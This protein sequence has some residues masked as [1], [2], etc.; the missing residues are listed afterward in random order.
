M[1]EILTTMTIAVPHA[2]FL[3]VETVSS[4]LV[5]KLAMMVTTVIKMNVQMIAKLRAVAM[6]LFGRVSK[7]VTMGI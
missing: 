2:P 3:F 4:K 6:E 7:S 5:L 1:M